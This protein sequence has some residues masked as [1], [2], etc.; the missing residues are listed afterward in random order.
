MLKFIITLIIC[1][2]S[3]PIFVTAQQS[4]NLEKSTVTS[5]QGK[6]SIAVSIGLLIQVNSTNEATLNGIDSN[7]RVDG[8]AGSLTY[9]YWLQPDWAIN[10]SIGILG[11]EA[12]ASVTGSEFSAETGSVIPILFGVRYQPSGLALSHSLRP[13]LSGAVG[14][15]WGFATKNNTRPFLTNKTISETAL[16]LRVA[17]GMDWF[18][19]RLFSIGVNAGYHFVSDFEQPVGSQKNYSGPEFSLNFGIIFGKGT[20][21]LK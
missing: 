3:S 6:N 21:K 5:L 17:A 20:N 13:Y 8:T 11:A 2:T 7:N 14:P 4:T 12:N 18:F 1:I 19:S 15:Y 9:T 10:F 16:G